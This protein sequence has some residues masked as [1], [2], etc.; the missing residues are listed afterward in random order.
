MAYKL[1]TRKRNAMFR[2]W[3]AKQAT[4]HVAK[5]CKIS[6]TTVTRYRALDNWDARWEEIQTKARAEADATNARSMAAMIDDVG[7]IRGNIIKALLA[8][9]EPDGQPKI[10]VWDLDKIIRLEQ[11]LKGHP[12]ARTEVVESPLDFLS[13][14]IHEFDER[15]SQ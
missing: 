5:H 9:T 15:Q 10:T 13:K 2:A 1:S 12:D 8:A 6:H 3:C 4:T 14:M 7:D 11:F